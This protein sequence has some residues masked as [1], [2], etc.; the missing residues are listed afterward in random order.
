MYCIYLLYI[1]CK[2]SYNFLFI[3]TVYLLSLEQHLV[4]FFCKYFRMFVFLTLNCVGNVFSIYFFSEI[5]LPFSLLHNLCMFCVDQKFSIA[6][7][8]GKSLKNYNCFCNQCIEDKCNTFHYNVMGEWVWCLAPLSITC[9]R[10]VVL[11][12]HSGFLHKW[13]WLPGYNWNIV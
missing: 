3:F 6:I 2:K 8:A 1:D 13:N 7:T 10:L 9:Y 5:T 12:G 11:S 4:L